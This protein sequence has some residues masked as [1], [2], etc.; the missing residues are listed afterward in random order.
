MKILRSSAP[1]LFIKYCNRL[2]ILENWRK[3]EQT[4]KQ[5]E[6]NVKIMSTLTYFFAF[7]F[8][9]M[10]YSVIGPSLPI[11]AKQYNWDIGALGIIFSLRAAG[12]MIGSLLGARLFDYFKGHKVLGI[13]VILLGLSLISIPFIGSI[14]LLF[15]IFTITGMFETS[16]DAGGNTLL[17][18]LHKEKSP[19]YMNALHLA[20]G[21]SAFIAPILVALSLNWKDNLITAYILISIPLFLFIPFFK[22]PSPKIQKSEQKKKSISNIKNILIMCS[23]FFFYAGLE[24][25]FGGWL[26]G[27]SIKLGYLT[28]NTA[29]YL[30]SVFFFTF[31]LGRLITIP[32]L[33][34]IKI[35]KLLLINCAATIFFFVIIILPTGIVGLWIGAGGVGLSLS[36]MFPGIFS[37]AE[38]RLNISGKISGYFIAGASFGFMTV[39]WIIGK[40]IESVMR[41]FRL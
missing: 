33:A 34:K 12:V 16:I 21:I 8:I 40:F 31:T 17:L 20:F 5:N 27:Y 28:E 25:G 38:R 23:F 30:A 39:S 7:I 15:S 26:P 9:G 36:S 19:P 29:P 6:K 22:V 35:Q 11:F 32:L 10:G 37:M 2:H 14:V 1:G 4:K 3:N 41:I 13:L 24:S 18:C